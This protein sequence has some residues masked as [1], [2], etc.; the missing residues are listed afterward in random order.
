M[1]PHL[2][3][4]PDRLVAGL[5]AAAGDFD[6]EACDRLFAVALAELEPLVLVRDVTSPALREAGNR[7]HR[8]EWSVV[9]E[10]MLSG[11]VRR[12]LSSALD[13]HLSH[14][15]GPTVLFTTLS[16]ERH[17]LG[18]LMGAFLAASRG[19]RSL[20][21]GPDLPAGDICTFCSHRHV[22]A[23]ALSLVTQPD[24]NDARGQLEELRKGVPATT[25][26]WV[27]GQ[28]ANLLAREH[29]PAGVE[30]IADLAGFL[31]RLARLKARTP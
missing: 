3:P 13:R 2:L 29:L 17:E 6:F 16:G 14:S 7:W 9:Q 21:L 8:G 25:E 26:I 24:V 28:A 4:A 5:L 27:A 31:D 30:G 10:H 23:L 1:D 12:Q 11:V 15:D 22:D 19:F 18:G 20:Y